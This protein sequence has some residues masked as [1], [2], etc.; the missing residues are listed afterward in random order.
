MMTDLFSTSVKKA[1][2]VQGTSPR[3]LRII[4]LGRN[5]LVSSFIDKEMR[6]G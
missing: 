5:T 4:F 1:E 6:K 3:N 2:Q